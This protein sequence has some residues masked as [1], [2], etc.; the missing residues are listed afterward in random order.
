[1]TTHFLLRSPAPGAAE[2]ILASNGR[3]GAYDLTF[4]QVCALAAQSADIKANWPHLKA[5]E[6]REHLV[7][8]LEAV[9]KPDPSQSS[10]QVTA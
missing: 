9:Q 8:V 1:M 6:V 2:I 7:K 10:Q 3:V 5:A 4:A